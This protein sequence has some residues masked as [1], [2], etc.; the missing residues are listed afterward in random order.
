MLL[1]RKIDGKMARLE[2]RMDKMSSAI[3]EMKADLT[4]LKQTGTK[5]SNIVKN[6]TDLEG[7]VSELEDQMFIVQDEMSYMK[8]GLTAI[9]DSIDELQEAENIQNENILFLAQEVD[10]I[11]DE[12]KVTHLF[13]ILLFV[14]FYCR[15]EN[16]RLE[17]IFANFANIA[18]FTKSSCS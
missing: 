17:E 15:T 1:D 14:F 18:R 12:A 7:R 13:S 3:T 8:L 10:Q 4:T 2:K 5:K 16:I 9:A 11:E 6:S